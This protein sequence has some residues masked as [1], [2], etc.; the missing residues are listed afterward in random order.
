MVCFI[1]GT[2]SALCAPSPLCG[3]G[4]GLRAPKVQKFGA[5]TASLLH[6]VEKVAEGWM[7]SFP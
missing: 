4:M 2:S 1:Q 5:A 3:E 6:E 7:R